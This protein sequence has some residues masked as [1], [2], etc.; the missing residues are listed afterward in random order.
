[1]ILHGLRALRDTL[2]QD[3]ELN[4]NNCSIAIVGKDHSFTS[5]EG[6]ELQR[7]LDLLAVSEASSGAAPDAAAAAAAVP[8]DTPAAMD[9]E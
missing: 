5:V 7:W 3:K 6:G 2:Q 8:A 4:I 1:V 9:T